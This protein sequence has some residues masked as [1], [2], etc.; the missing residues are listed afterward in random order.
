[1]LTTL[2]VYQCDNWRAHLDVNPDQDPGEKRVHARDG[3][4]DQ[5]AGLLDAGWVEVRQANGSQGLHCPTCVRA[6]VAS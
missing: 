5:L 1:M 2:L 4:P 3:W 6:G